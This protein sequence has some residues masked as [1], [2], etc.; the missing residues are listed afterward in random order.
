MY[1]TGDFARWLPDGNMEFVGRKDSQ[2]KIRGYRIELGEIEQALQ[3]EANIYHA[4]VLVKE[5]TGEKYIIAFLVGKEIETTQLRDCLS[6][7]LPA[8]MIPAQY[9]VLD[10]IPLTPSGKTDKKQLLTMDLIKVN[11]NKYLRPNTETEKQLVL[12]W[13]N[14]LTK[15]PI[16]ISDNFFELGGHSLHI[17]RMMY[18]INETF[19]IKLQMKNAFSAQTIRQLSKLIE[20]EVVFKKG[21]TADETKPKSKNIKKSEVWEI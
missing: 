8:Y 10:D 21:I 1:D 2:V 11:T 13:E 9:L 20:D 3:E 6:E 17:T 7:K 5:V 15:S 19:G 14:L 12:I 18:E 16:G 4:V